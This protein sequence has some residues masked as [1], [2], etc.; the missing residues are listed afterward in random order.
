MWCAGPNYSEAV[1]LFISALQDWLEDMHLHT[2]HVI[3]SL[4]VGW[5]ESLLPCSLARKLHDSKQT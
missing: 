1:Q 3:N 2:E 4:Q 5:H